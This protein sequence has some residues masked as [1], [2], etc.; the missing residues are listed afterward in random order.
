[1][2][3][4]I[5]FLQPLQVSILSEVSLL[6][7]EPY[8]PVLIPSYQRRMRQPY[9]MEGGEPGVLGKNTWIKQPRKEDGDYLEGD[10]VP[11]KPRNI[12]IGGKVTIFMGKGDH[13]L[14][15]TPGVGGWGEAV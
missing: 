11:L 7:N 8:C 4:E 13:L 3:C 1:V 10:E 9:G 15:E 2:V 14:I 5:E 6:C 12:N